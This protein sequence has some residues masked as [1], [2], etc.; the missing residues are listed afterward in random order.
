MSEAKSRKWPTIIIMTVAVISV[1]VGDLIMSRAM[2][3]LGPLNIESFASWW[4]G[5]VGIASVA[6]E[7]YDLGW[8]IFGQ[9]LVWLAIGFMLTFLILWMIALSWSDLTFVMPL[10]AL[11]YVLNAML[12]GPAL[13]EE[14]SPM[15]WAGTLLIAVG[16]ALVSADVQDPDNDEQTVQS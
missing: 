2:R 3:S 1:T 16:V 7:F 11:T 5:K 4:S 13:G 14:V 9:P 12:V 10:T 8:R 6:Y 15:R